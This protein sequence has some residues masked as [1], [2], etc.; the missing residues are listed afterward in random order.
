MLFLP[1]YSA[2][3]HSCGELTGICFIC[4]SRESRQVLYKFQLNT[5]EEL[6]TLNLAAI[7][8]GDASYDQYLYQQ[9]LFLVCT[10]GKHDQCCAKF[11][12]PIYNELAKHMGE[13]AWQC[14]HL[15]G[16]KF[17]AN[18][19]CLPHGIYYGYVSVADVQLI[20]E[21]YCQNQLYDKKYRGI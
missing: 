1:P 21:A 6:P 10:H 19:L 14:S 13:Q 3:T 9:P 11:G 16:D 15:G 18:M 20:V 2:L 17:A 5:Y 12:I 8:S 7:L 4:I